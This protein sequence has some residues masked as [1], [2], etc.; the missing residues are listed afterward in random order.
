MNQYIA[1]LVH[2][3]LV[4]YSLSF[5]IK[6]AMPFWVKFLLKARSQI[7]MYVCILSIWIVPHIV[8][9]LNGLFQRFLRENNIVL[10]FGHFVPCL[11]RTFCY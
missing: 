7:T 9:R 4:A 1:I 2:S 6:G 3:T 5:K 8:Y 10:K 11:L